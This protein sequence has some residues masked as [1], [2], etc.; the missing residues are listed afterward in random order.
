MFGERA[1]PRRHLPATALPDGFDPVCIVLVM[2]R[3]NEVRSRPRQS[4][5]HPDTL[6]APSR[7]ELCRNPA[8]SDIRVQTP[9]T[10]ALHTILS[11]LE[12]TDARGRDEESAAELKLIL[13]R[14]IQEVENCAAIPPRAPRAAKV[15]NNS[16]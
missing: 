10:D 15:A 2:R 7:I 13:K 9:L 3:R 6:S 14:R 5:A 8:L 4:A 12:L 16:D 11:N 1:K